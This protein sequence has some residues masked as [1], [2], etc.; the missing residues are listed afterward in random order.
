MDM[1]AQ[2][3]YYLAAT[4]AAVL[5]AIVNLIVLAKLYPSSMKAKID[6]ALKPVLERM[7]T[8]EVGLRHA[9]GES[10]EQSQRHDR[11]LK[12]FDTE[13]SHR[14]DALRESI[15]AQDKQLAQ[16]LVAV[17]HGVTRRDV[18]TLHHRVTESAKSSAAT[19]QAIQT[20]QV[21]LQ[22]IEEFLREGS[23]G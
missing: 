21:R 4:V 12:A 13:V 11:S 7:E 14:L 2:D 1:N 19:Q 8:L 18:D 6:Q 9:E 10:K 16:L 22:N 5:A 23:R 20:L 15:H 3:T 17:Q